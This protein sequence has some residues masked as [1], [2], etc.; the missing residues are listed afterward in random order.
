MATSLD[1][2]YRLSSLSSEL[3]RL[4]A[5]NDVGLVGT[6]ESTVGKKDAARWNEGNH[7]PPSNAEAVTACSF[8]FSIPYAPKA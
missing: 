2:H 1:M 6:G 8:T 4:K 5:D 3:G 7:S